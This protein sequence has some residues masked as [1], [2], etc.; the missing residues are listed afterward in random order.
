LLEDLLA[1]KDMLRKSWA[2]GKFQGPGNAV[3]TVAAVNS[4]VGMSAGTYTQIPA[5]KQD[6]PKYHRAGAMILALYTQI[7]GPDA[8]T[9]I[10]VSLAASKI[11]QFNDSP[12]VTHD[13]VL[14]AVD[15]AIAEL[16]S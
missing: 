6:D 12:N 1:V 13:T 5:S 14:L 8:P 2:K 15:R 10:T 11:A 16:M 4:V 9:D 3:C 7:Y